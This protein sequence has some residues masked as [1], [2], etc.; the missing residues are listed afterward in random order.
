METKIKIIPLYE[1]IKKI[2]DIVIDGNLCKEFAYDQIVN[3]SCFVNTP[4]T[5]KMFI[6]NEKLFEGEFTKGLN[7]NRGYED[8]V[9]H[10]HNKTIDWWIKVYSLWSQ[11][12]E[13]CI[14]KYNFRD[15]LYI[16]K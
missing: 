6:G 9:S 15:S 2:N 1:Y 10:I 11:P 7:P 16:L 13:Y 14:K 3:Y 12:T 8:I 5:L 4:L